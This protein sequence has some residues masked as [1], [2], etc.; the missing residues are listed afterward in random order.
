MNKHAKL[1]NPDEV[2]YTAAINAT[3][4]CEAEGTTT[5]ALPD[6]LTK[7]RQQYAIGDEPFDGRVR[8]LTDWFYLQEVLPTKRAC[9][10]Y[11][12][13]HHFAAAVILWVDKRYG[14]NIKGFRSTTY[15]AAL[16]SAQMALWLDRLVLLGLL[17]SESSRHK[18]GHNVRATPKLIA[19]VSSLLAGGGF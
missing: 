8:Q 14:V 10:H 11:Q 5:I 9:Q 3:S 19:L 4:L 1:T 17:E 18:A 2:T 6:L 16:G 7:A 12:S 15:L 13:H